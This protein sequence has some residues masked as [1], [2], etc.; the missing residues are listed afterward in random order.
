[1]DPR[2][3]DFVSIDLPASKFRDEHRGIAVPF[4]LVK[5]QNSFRNTRV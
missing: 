3:V 5:S 1:V 2:S 4:S